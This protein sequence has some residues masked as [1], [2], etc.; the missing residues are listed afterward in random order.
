MI[1]VLMLLKKLIN[2]L[3]VEYND[4]FQQRAIKMGAKVEHLVSTD[5]NRMQACEQIVN[6]V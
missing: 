4:G 6:L 1:D 5:E 3:V 2:I